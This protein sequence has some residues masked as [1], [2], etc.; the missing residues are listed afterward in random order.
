MAERDWN[1]PSIVIVSILN[2]SWGAHLK[3]PADRQWL[4]QA[5]LEAKKMVPGWLVED[6]SACCDNFHV[7][8]DLADTHTYN[9]IPD[10]AATFDQFVGDLAQRPRWL[11]SPYGDATP[12]GD[13]PLMLSEFGNWGLPKVPETKPWWF[14]R[15]FGG[16]PLTLPADLEQRFADYQYASLFPTLDALSEA[17]QWQQFRALKYEI[18]SLRLHPEIQGYVIT[19]FTDLNW[20]ANGLLD[21]WRRPKVY[22][23]A[24]SRLQQDDLILARA[25]KRNLTTGAEARV[26][27]Y[28]SHHSE[29]SLAGAQVAWRL[30]GTALKGISP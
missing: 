24:L 6:N 2:E 4:K 16:R 9:A 19:E 7:A 13:E 11:Y 25:D 28:F 1:H 29:I 26:D 27:V 18:E 10:Y 12:R 21:M 22:A 3:E 8:G 15:D 14:S 30:E 5:Y 20:E 17:T 23:D